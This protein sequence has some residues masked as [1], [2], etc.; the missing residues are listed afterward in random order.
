VLTICES[1][2]VLVLQDLEREKLPHH[3]HAPHQKEKVDD[4]D[5]ITRLSLR[6]TCCGHVLRLTLSYR[7]SGAAD[8][9]YTLNLN[10]TIISE[11]GL[12]LLERL[13]PSYLEL[14]FALLERELL[15]AGAELGDMQ[16][17]RRG[18]VDDHDVPHSQDEDADTD[19]RQ[20]HRS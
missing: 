19:D 10:E 15:R 9:F 17:T 3:E 11:L 4:L 1:D 14:E 8:V 2:V 12:E 20:Q 6:S 16:T 7:T 13:E 18:A 5:T